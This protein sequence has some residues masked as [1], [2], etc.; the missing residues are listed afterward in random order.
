MGIKKAEEALLKKAKEEI[1]KIEDEKKLKKADWL[2]KTKK[3]PKTDEEERVEHEELC[4]RVI[5]GLKNDLLTTKVPKAEKE[6]EIV[7]IKWL[8]DNHIKM[9]NN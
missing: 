4:N 2:K 1:K 7:K 6:V 5:N 9:N 3:K 8:I